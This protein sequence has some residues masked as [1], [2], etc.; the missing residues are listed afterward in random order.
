MNKNKLKTKLATQLKKKK[1]SI[2]TI[3]KTSLKVNKKMLNK[4][5]ILPLVFSPCH[6]HKY[7]QETYGYLCSSHDISANQQ[8]KFSKLSF[9]SITKNIV[10]STFKK[11]IDLN[12]M[13]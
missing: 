2:K 13:K 12:R 1:S 7:H 9:L 4:T 5:L 8:N 3:L 6:S 10:F 11:S